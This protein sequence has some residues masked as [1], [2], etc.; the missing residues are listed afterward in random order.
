MSEYPNIA[1][2]L[3]QLNDDRDPQELARNM[4]Q[5]GDIVLYCPGA[6]FDGLDPKSPA[7][8]AIVTF[9]RDNSDRLDLHVLTRN[10]SCVRTLVDYADEPHPGCWTWREASN[11]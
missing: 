5:V 4:P 8:A 2:R 6:P 11:R 7:L 1:A 9:V 3:A 10:G